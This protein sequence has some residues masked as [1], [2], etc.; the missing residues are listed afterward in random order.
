MPRS[1]PPAPVPDDQDV[2]LDEYEVRAGGLD[3][4]T[5][6]AELDEDVDALERDGTAY[7]EALARSELE[8]RASATS[9][10]LLHHRRRLV[11]RE[12][13]PLAALF[14]GGQSPLADARRKQHRALVSREILYTMIGRGEPAPS[15]T[16]LERMANADGRHVRFVELLE[17]KRVRFVQLKNALSEIQEQIRNRELTLVAYSAEARLSR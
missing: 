15:E 13:A 7:M 10:A 2:S 4:S 3:E 1:K 17:A 6:L 8:E 11:L 14:D 9:L 12:L 5:V 16:A